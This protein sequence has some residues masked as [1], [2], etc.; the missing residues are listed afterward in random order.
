ME[1][2]T[3]EQLDAIKNAVGY[4]HARQPREGWTK[5]EISEAVDI[6][7]KHAFNS[8][9]L[10]KA[11]ADG[12]A[13]SRQRRQDLIEQVCKTRKAVRTLRG[14][15]GRQQHQPEYFGSEAQREVAL[16]DEMLTAQDA[17]DHSDK[18]SEEERTIEGVLVRLMQ[19]RCG[20]RPSASIEEWRMILNDLVT[21]ERE[22]I[23]E[24]IERQ[25]EASLHVRR[26][27]EAHYSLRRLSHVLVKAKQTT[28]RRAL[29]QDTCWR[30]GK[31][32]EPRRAAK[33]DREELMAGLARVWRDVIGKAPGK[34]KDASQ[35]APF[36]IFADT[37]LKSFDFSV[38]DSIV[39]AVHRLDQ[40]RDLP[41]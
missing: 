17:R 41:D 32:D 7:V 25:K 14:Y 26:L 36:Y 11:L 40:D 1:E 39:R 2:L 6:A 28:R 24:R 10:G 9:T 29:K 38:S 18:A 22:T 13:F 31:E 12:D 37:I 15:L 19:E 8:A 4:L 3:K 16:M 27:R 21:A 35:Q 34:S 33:P 5:E 30:K 23:F 20:S